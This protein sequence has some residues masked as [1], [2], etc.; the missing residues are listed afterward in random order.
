MQDSA[1][2]DLSNG[3][4]EQQDELDRIVYLCSESLRICGILLQ[5]YMPSKMKHL[6]DLLGVDPT[7]RLFMNAIRP[8]YEYGTPI[9]D[10]GRGT[11]GVVFPPLRSHF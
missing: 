10:V 5:P 8:D 7:A 3:A 6:L 1:P 2:W 11:E 9:V 4:A